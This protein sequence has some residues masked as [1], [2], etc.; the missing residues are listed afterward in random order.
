[1]FKNKSSIKKNLIPNLDDSCVDSRSCLSKDDNI[2][3][4]RKGF[5]G[6]ECQFKP[7]SW[8]L[9]GN[10][11]FS[12]DTT[13]LSFLTKNKQTTSATIE[14]ILDNSGT[15]KFNYINLVADV[16]ATFTVYIDD[17]PTVLDL[18][19]SFA[20]IA[21]SQGLHVI[22][23]VY[24]NLD[25]Q[26]SEYL[27]TISK[28]SVI[29]DSCIDL[30]VPYYLLGYR[31]LNFYDS[32]VLSVPKSN[33]RFI[34]AGISNYG[35]T[36]ESFMNVAYLISEPISLKRIFAAFKNV[37][38][39]QCNNCIGNIKLQIYYSKCEDGKY[40]D[41]VASNL[42]LSIKVSANGSY[43]ANEVGSLDLDVSDLI[44]IGVSS[45]DCISCFRL[46]VNIGSI[47]LS[48]NQVTINSLNNYSLIGCKGCNNK[49]K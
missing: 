11:S 34:S 28:W 29:Y 26:I 19:E 24:V 23:L 27:L 1:M 30:T 3:F 32:N 35:L 39:N 14:T 47:D 40:A 38:M 33:S 25:T 2:S 10:A 22:K 5:V 48:N 13:E 37:K 43:C 4:Q 16:N 17:Q 31:Y 12:P 18:S 41:P 7:D 46:A 20:E 42:S 36:T 49:I 21:I 9:Q 8:V 15:I 45:D 44:A 6:F